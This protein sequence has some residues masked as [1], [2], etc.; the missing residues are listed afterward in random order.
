MQVFGSSPHQRWT[1]TAIPPQPYQPVAASLSAT[2]FRL[3]LC[4]HVHQSVAAALLAWLVS[5]T[6]RQA[7]HFSSKPKGY[8]QVTRPPTSTG[9]H[10]GRLQ[11]E[12]QSGA[13][14]GSG[15]VALVLARPHS[16]RPVSRTL[17]G[18]SCSTSARSGSPWPGRTA[19][20]HSPPVLHQG[21]ADGLVVVAC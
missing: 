20:P 6:S 14:H 21:C 13:C 12:A 16:A 10:Q 17:S 18:T 19:V 8:D 3:C 9:R 2:T 5:M 4:A 15:P 11:P 1:I 7:G